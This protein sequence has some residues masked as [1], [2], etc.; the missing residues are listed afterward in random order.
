MSVQRQQESLMQGAD[1]NQV[2]GRMILKEGYRS[3][4]VLPFAYVQN[5]SRPEVKGE[6]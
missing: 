4:D 3:E 1:M 6:S 5:A 2:Q